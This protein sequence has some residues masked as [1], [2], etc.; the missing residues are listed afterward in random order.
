MSEIK[1]LPKSRV[2]FEIEIK[3]E[4]LE[5]YKDKA[6]K[7][8]SNEIQVPGFR[9]GHIP[10]DII[11]EQVEKKYFDAVLFE[12]AFPDIYAKFVTDNNINIISR[13]K[14][15]DK[16]RKPWIVKVVVEV[17]PEVSIGDYKKIKIPKKDVKV[18]KN[19]VEK[20]ISQI[21]VRNA[22]YT[23]KEG[24]SKKG[25]RVE[26]NFRGFV[27]E[28]VYKDELT[29]K[30]HP[31]IL[32]SNA[33]VPGFEDQLVGLKKGDKK[34]VKVT[35]PKD[36]HNKSYQNKKVTF[37][38]EVLEVE[39]VNK[40]EINEEFIKN[41]LKR[42]LSLEE[43]KKEIEQNI[44]NKIIDNQRIERENKL[45]DELYKIIKT[46]LPESMIKEEVDYM[47]KDLEKRVAGNN[48]DLEKFLNHIKKTE[49][50]LRDGYKEDAEKRIT[51]QLGIAEIIKKENIVIPKEEIEKEIEKRL[52]Y[53]PKSEINSIRA[54]YKE[55][56]HDYSNLLYQLKI[57]KIV[58]ECLSR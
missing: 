16:S 23:I 5:K 51:I 25:D 10:N 43:F 20:V 48:M 36:Y 54:K 12:T 42:D 4:V 8:I 26:I 14:I 11:E 1:K 28:G 46:D 41:V 19:D 30:H 31:L 13:P 58:Q 7:K 15:E 18:N 2:E 17:I 38:V 50:E 33:F 32:G 37:E 53:A 9:S 44:L 56:S 55:G 3:D 57:D 27:E 21:Q 47:M 24:V 22:K 34:E 6:Y 39:D 49:Q 40:P 35:F 45:M 52:V 29:S